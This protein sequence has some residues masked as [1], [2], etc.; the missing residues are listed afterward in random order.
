MARKG[1]VDVKTLLRVLAVLVSGCALSASARE[2]S[3]DLSVFAGLAGCWSLEQDGT[4]YEEWW[5]RPTSNDLLGMAR[6]IRN[7]RATNF[8][9]TR[10]VSDEQGIAYLAYPGGKG[11]TRFGLVSFAGSM[12]TFENLKHDFPTR[13]VYALRAA[14]VLDARIEGMVDGKLRRIDYPFRRAPCP[15][16]R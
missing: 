5:M 10:I 6:T 1:E 13:I 15:A 11:P 8:E 14:D 16:G 7:G 12:A 4:R 9:Y 3:V 2:E